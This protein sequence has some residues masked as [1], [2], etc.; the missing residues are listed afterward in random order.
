MGKSKK[1]RNQTAKK[2]KSNPESS[3]KTDA[4]KKSSFNYLPLVIAAALIVVIVG[5]YFYLT[6]NDSAPETGTV[7][8]IQ[9]AVPTN[10]SIEEPIS[11]IP[12]DDNALPKP[13]LPPGRELVS[14]SDFKAEPAQLYG[15][16]TDYNQPIEGL[17]V[18]VKPLR[19]N[20][21]ASELS[22][23]VAIDGTFQF[24][25]LLSGQVK[26]LLS[27]PGREVSVGQDRTQTMPPSQRLL[28]T[29]VLEPGQNEHEF[30]VESVLLVDTLNI[31]VNV[32]DQPVEGLVIF[33]RS[34]E[35]QQQIYSQGQRRQVS[36]AESTQGVVAATTDAN[37]IAKFE[38]IFPGQWTFLVRAPDGSWSWIYPNYFDPSTLKGGGVLTFAI[39][40]HSGEVLALNAVDESPLVNTELHLY[41]N[42]SEPGFRLTTDSN[43]RLLAD[44]PAGDYYVETYPRTLQN[45]AQIAWSDSE[46]NQHQVKIAPKPTN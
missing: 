4:S 26:V 28:S 18:V 10:R 38:G 5:A 1:P 42:F 12:S 19:D 13:S 24:A 2:T 7:T 22:Q 29:I 27:L 41:S 37:G 43:G 45:P 36:S 31:R 35:A 40:T 15:Q 39:T 32:N 30:S 23:P 34:L 3:R 25:E 17:N 21:E 6:P 11:E 8:T 9:P 46:E 16:L 44:L 20:S 33:G 14:A